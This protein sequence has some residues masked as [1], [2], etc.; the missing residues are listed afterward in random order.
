MLKIVQAE[1]ETQIAAVRELFREYETS[2]DIDLCFQ[3]FEDELRGL[4]GKYSPPGGRLLL[5][6]SDG[7]AAGC[8]AMRD[9]GGSICEMKRLFVRD[10][11]RGQRA[12]KRLIERIIDEARA[13][14]YAKMRLDTAPKK[15][16]KAVDIY[17]MYGFC[18]IPPYYDN[19]HEDVMYMELAL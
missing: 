15:M 17:R 5:A 9:L 3:G 14:G 19:P 11:F 18:E 7:E 2:M 1:S 16:A 8:I 10:A 13:E 4:P 12:G 6:E